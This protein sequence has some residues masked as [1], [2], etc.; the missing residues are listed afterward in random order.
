M[1][2]KTHPSMKHMKTHTQQNSAGNS[3]ASNADHQSHR[4]T[5]CHSASQ[6]LD[7]LPSGFRSPYSEALLTPGHRPAN[8]GIYMFTLPRQHS[9]RTQA[10]DLQPHPARLARGSGALLC[11][12]NSRTPQLWGAARRPPSPLLPGLRHRP[13]SSL[14]R[15]LRLTPA[16]TWAPTAW[17]G[18]GHRAAE[19]TLPRGVSEALSKAPGDRTRLPC[20]PAPTAAESDAVTGPCR[21]PQRLCGRLGGTT[22]P[23]SRSP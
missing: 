10:P 19:L 21:P 15:R 16:L 6:H 9:R 4:A 13:P 3:A 7:T 2:K 14:Q 8:S 18:R 5:S 1:C 17:L 20:T 22:S 23:D 11:P 12:G